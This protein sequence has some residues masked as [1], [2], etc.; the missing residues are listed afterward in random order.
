[1]SRADN[2]VMFIGRATEPDLGYGG[3]GLAYCRFALGLYEGKNDDG[4]YKDSSW[5]DVTV[6]GDQA[7]NVAN[8]VKKGD[9]VGV[10]GRITQDRWENDAGDKRTKLKV[11]ADEVMT[12]LRWAQVQVTRVEVTEGGQGEVKVTAGHSEDPF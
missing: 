4:S 7:E 6:F 1:M 11:I 8:S 10:V 5:V 9:R 3:S 12:S 2:T